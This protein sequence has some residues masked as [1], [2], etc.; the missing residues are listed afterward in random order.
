MQAVETL[1][2]KTAPAKQKLSASREMKHESDQELIKAAI[3]IHDRTQ[4][5]VVFAY[6]P[7][8]QGAAPT[9][10]Q[11]YQV[12]AWFF[13]PPATGITPQ[14]YPKVKFYNDLRPLLRL[15]EPRLRYKE[16]LGDPACSDLSPI[17]F[18]RNYLEGVR[19]GVASA[20]PELVI[21]EIHLFACSYLSYSF[22]KVKRRTTKLRRLA[23]GVDSPEARELFAQDFEKALGVIQKSHRILRA[24]R[25]IRADAEAM[26]A[27]LLS[28]VRQEIALA[29]EYCSYA[30][31]DGVA[32]VMQMLPDLDG[33]LTE[34]EASRCHGRLRTFLRY[35]RRYARQAHTIWMDPDDQLEQME[36]YVARR[37]ALKKH[38]Q[39]VLYLDLR[40][41]PMFA[42][43]QQL[44]G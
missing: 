33:W 19:A 40:T 15:R 44:G 20:S 32:I 43:Q 5:E 13:V 26:P 27:D 30:F 24:W 21:D 9:A 25:K 28:A 35:E 4:V 41:K 10:S 16:L 34:E 29:D 12:D 18:I 6:L 11:S 8:R 42:F 38:M 7:H 3:G 17:A 39:R 2:E 36:R 14:S 23:E 1:G 37:S 22:R 31:R